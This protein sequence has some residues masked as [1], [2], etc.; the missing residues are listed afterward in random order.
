MVAPPLAATTRY[1]PVSVRHWYWVPTIANLSAPS[2]AELNAGTDLTGQIPQDGVAGFSVKSNL[3]DAGDMGSRF[4]S[5]ISGLIQADDSTM[6]FYMSST[7]SDVRSLLTQDLTGYIVI[8]LEGDIAG[9]KMDAYPVTV[10]SVSKENA[11]ANPATLTV[12]F[13]ITAVPQVNLTVP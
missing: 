4:V 13:A 8:L 3:V 2:R 9:R 6:T 5:K 7:S 12:T 1:I 11:G 10:S